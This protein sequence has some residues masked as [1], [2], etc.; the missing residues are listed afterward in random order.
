MGIGIRSLFEKNQMKN[1]SILIT[2]EII[3]QLSFQLNILLKKNKS[4]NYWKIILTP[5]VSWIVSITYPLYVFYIHII[6]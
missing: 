3:N 5:Y 1:K 2:D 6:A 4:H